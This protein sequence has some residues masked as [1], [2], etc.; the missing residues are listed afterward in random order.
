M[1]LP[2]ST[3]RLGVPSGS[4]QQS[5]IELFGRAGY[6]ISVDGRSVFPRVDDDKISAVLFRSQEI[7]RYVVDGIIDC[8]L[9]GYDWIVE[10][11]N[12]DDVVEVL[13][14]TY[15]RATSLPARWVLAVP[16]E[17]PIKTVQD[18]EGKIVAT[19]IVNTVR[20]YFD[21]HGVKVNVEFSWGT[22]EIK[23]RL[24]DGIVDLTETGSSIRANNLR[25]IDTILSS[26]IRFI[27]NKQAWAVPWKREK[28]ENI[29]MLLQGAIAARSKVGLKMNVPEAKLAEV[30]SFL[31]AEKSPTISRLADGDWVA[32]EVI[33][34]DKQERELIPRLK[35]AGATGI[36]TY[37][38]NKVIP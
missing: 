13:E 9:C 35:R 25:V 31:P 12:Q 11:G 29:A 27:A 8:G 6:K 2:E 37:P 10:N 4:M 33:L 19:E 16:D 26:T 1:T 17:S 21:K 30:T 18:F 20:R 32:V 3:L 22:T 7:S 28:M 14:L 15:S 5:T 34:E 24:L 38:L 36:I 23:A